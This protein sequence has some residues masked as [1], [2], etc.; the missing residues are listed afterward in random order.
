[1]LRRSALYTIFIASICLSCGI[2]SADLIIVNGKII[3][4]DPEHSIEEA[5]AIQSDR[6]LAVGSNIMIDKYRGY[7]TIIIDAE[8]KSVLPGFNDAHCHFVS[9]SK[10][11]R[12]LDFRNINSIDTIKEMIAEKIDELPERALILGFHYDHTLFPDAKFPDKSDLDPISPNNPVVI[13][14]IDGHSCWVNS[15]ALKMAGIGPKTKSPFGGEIVTDQKTGE[16]SGIL[17]ESAMDLLSVLYE[18]ADEPATIKDDVLKGL[19]YANS[20]GITSVHTSAGLNE[21]EFF[22]ELKKEGKLTLRIYAWQYLDQLDSLLQLNI[23]PGDGDN[24]LRVG[25]LKSYIDGTLGSGTAL[26]FEPYSD[27]PTTNGLIQ[28]PETVYQ[29]KIARAHELGYQTGTHAIGDKGVNVVLNSIEYAQQNFGKRGLR[30]RIEHAQIVID[31]DFTRFSDLGVIASMQ[32]THC[33]TDLRFCEQRIGA[34]RS[35]GAYAWRTFIDNGVH[36][37][38]G[39]DWPV[40]PLDPLRGIYSA[41]TRKNIETGTPEGGWYPE[42]KLSLTEALEAYTMG[43][44]YASFEEELKGSLE[45]GKLADIIVLDKDLYAIE[46]EEIL[47]TRVRFT[48]LGGKIVYSY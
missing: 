38:F 6:I 37:A 9:G 45:A 15:L 25:F 5:I 12:T 20:L 24:E 13:E 21:F 33:T 26:M 40:E 3:T 17:K 29:Q 30:H 36:I 19:T 43:S 11:L 8:Q 2:E 48:I 39:T 18:S 10:S 27:A 22:N 46:P 28:Y 44:A 47:T 14:R 16:P 4:L 34:A 41:V 1:M 32:P 35:K 23:K 7:D 42:Q 31:Q